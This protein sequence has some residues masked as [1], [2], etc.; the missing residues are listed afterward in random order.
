M[1]MLPGTGN[2]VAEIKVTY[3]I[4]ECELCHGTGSVPHDVNNLDDDR[5]DD[6]PNCDGRGQ[7][8]EERWS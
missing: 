3:E 7:Y 5:F 2:S 6:C 4:V 8:K 1:K